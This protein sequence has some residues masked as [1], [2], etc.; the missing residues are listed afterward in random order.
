MDNITDNPDP[1]REGVLLGDWE[2]KYLVAC[3]SG[4]RPP[5]W[6]I[7]APRAN[8]DRPGSSKGQEVGLRAERELVGWTGL[9]DYVLS[10]D[11]LDGFNAVGIAPED[12]DYFTVNFRGK[13][14]SRQAGLPMGWS[15][16]P[17]YFC[18]LTYAS[19]MPPYA[20][21]R[22]CGRA[23]F[24][25]LATKP[26]WVYLRELH[27]VLRTKDSW[28]GRVKMTHQLRRDLEWWGAVPN[29]SS[30]RSIY[31]PVE[32]A[33]MPVESSGYRCGVVLNETTEARCF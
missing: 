16:N 2:N 31:M 19:H 5:S 29:L 28:S 26:A 9:G 24:L 22:L 10:M 32:T 30:G 15:L 33:Y 6:D 14:Y 8:R 13:L 17:N 18:S 27:D 4:S 12:R 25:Y 23:H 3:V 7:H 1:Y 21:P 11:L 20:T